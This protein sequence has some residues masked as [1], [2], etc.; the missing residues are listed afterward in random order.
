MSIA[1][2]MEDPSVVQIEVHAFTKCIVCFQFVVGTD[3]K[4]FAEAC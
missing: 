2:F 4:A 1:S 3:S